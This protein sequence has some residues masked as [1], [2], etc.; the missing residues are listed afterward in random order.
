VLDPASLEERRKMVAQNQ[1]P[2]QFMAPT[3]IWNTVVGYDGKW[4][5]RPLTAKLEWENVTNVYDPPAAFTTTQPMRIIGTVS[6]R[7]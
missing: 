6:V 2:N 1:N 7:F 5:R 3:T 4:G